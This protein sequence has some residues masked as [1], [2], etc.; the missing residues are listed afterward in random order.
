MASRKDT[1]RRWV[2]RNKQGKFR[3]TAF[4]GRSEVVDWF[5]GGCIDYHTKEG[6]VFVAKRL[7]A[8][9]A[10]VLY[11]PNGKTPNEAYAELILLSIASGEANHG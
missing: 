8:P 3:S 6:A 2:V 11:V 9:G 5:D 1:E 10:T 4:D 7:C